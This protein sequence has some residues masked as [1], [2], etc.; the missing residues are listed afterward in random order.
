MRKLPY[1]HWWPVALGT[2]AIVGLLI[3]VFWPNHRR[4]RA[5]TAAVVHASD[6]L[7]IKLATL[8]QVPVRKHQIDSLVR[9]LGTFRASLYHT[10]QV[11]LAMR[12]FEGRA[13]AAG[14]ECWI[15]NPSLPTLITLEASRDSIAA[16]N[17]ALLPVEFECLGDFLSVGR[18]LEAEE[19]EPQ[20]CQWEQLTVTP[21]PGVDRVRAHALVQLFLLPAEDTE[22]EAS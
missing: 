5:H 19:M 13:R 21:G 15:L 11:D 1:W 2:L 4:A 22:R 9:M 16:L 10:N 3:F 12:D 8:E 17:L 18:F 20:F 6:E 7:R 14:V